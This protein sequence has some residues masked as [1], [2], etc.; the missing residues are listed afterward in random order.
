MEEA[1]RPSLVVDLPRCRVDL[2]TK[3]VTCRIDAAT[4]RCMYGLDPQ[5]NLR[6]IFEVSLTAMPDTR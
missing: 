1:A 4:L 2:G 5:V 3:V 6:F